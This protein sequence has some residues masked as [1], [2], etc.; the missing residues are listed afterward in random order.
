L[1]FPL[2]M[3]VVSHGQRGRRAALSATG[4]VRGFQHETLPPCG[5]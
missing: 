3:L 1:M 5:A 4:A 2:A